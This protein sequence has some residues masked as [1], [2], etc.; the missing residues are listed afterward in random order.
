MGKIPFS[1]RIVSST[2][3]AM[4]SQRLSPVAA[5][6]RRPSSVTEGTRESPLLYSRWPKPM[7]FSFRARAS[8]TH[9]RARSVSP[10]SSIISMAAS[11]APP[12]RGPMR[13]AMPAVT[14][15]CRSDR[16]EA[17]TLAAKEEALKPCSE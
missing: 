3:S 15:A 12:W 5:A 16:V 7:I 2:A 8:S 6:T 14:A 10:I 4:R 9:G 11:L 17:V 13:A 1:E